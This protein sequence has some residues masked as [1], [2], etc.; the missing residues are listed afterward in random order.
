MIKLKLKIGSTIIEVLLAATLISTAILASLALSSS[1]QKQTD[2]S[3]DFNT[4]TVYN[5]QAL[6]WLRSIRTQ[7]GWR[8][9]TN[10]LDLDTSGN[11]VTYCLSSLPAAASFAGLTSNPCDENDPADKIAGTSFMREVTLTFSGSPPD[12]VSA[13]ISTFWDLRAHY[14]TA[15]TTLTEW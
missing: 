7:T 3:R 15:E 14:A 9:F 12:T 1:S 5:N 13:V 8:S 4:A 11:S 6:D 10:E 2:F